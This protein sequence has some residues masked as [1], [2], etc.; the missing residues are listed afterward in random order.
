MVVRPTGST[1][2]I[3]AAGAGKPGGHCARGGGEGLTMTGTAWLSVLRRA[4]FCNSMI[5]LKRCST[6]IHTTGWKLTAAGARAGNTRRK[7]EQSAECADAHYVLGRTP[8][9]DYLHEYAYR[10]GVG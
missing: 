10:S 4:R 1:G 8:K 9:E 3:S 2:S 6:A 5:G 7:K